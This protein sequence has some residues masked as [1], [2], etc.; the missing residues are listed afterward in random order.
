MGRVQ[1]EEHNGQHIVVS[2]C[3]N[4]TPAELIDAIE[5]VQAIVTA[6]PPNSVH[7]LTD[8]SG[9]HFD[10]DSIQR[11]KEAAAFDRPHIIRAAFVGVET[12]PEVY[13]KAIENFSARHFAKFQ[14]KEEAI[15]YLTEDAAGRQS[16]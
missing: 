13:Y 7:T 2:D 10:K 8:F 5:Q 3:R 15:Q 16:A 14:T 1:L 11:L 9:A 4:C 12:L 6:Q